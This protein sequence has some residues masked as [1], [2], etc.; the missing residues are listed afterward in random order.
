MKPEIIV[1]K[2][3]GF[4][5][6]VDRAV[7]MCD[8][9]LDEGYKVATLGPIIH[10]ETVVRRLESKGCIIIK[11]PSEAPEGTTVVIRSHGVPASVYE[12]C[13]KAG[14]N[15][16]DAT[17]PFVAKIHKIAQKTGEEGRCLV[18]AGDK[19]H[20]E[21]QGIVGHCSGDVFVV[22]DLDE[23][24]AAAEKIG[25]REAVM[26]SQTTFSKEKF[27]VL[28]EF[29]KK[30]YTTFSVFDTI[31]N[32]TNMRQKE[33]LELSRECDFCIVIG[34]MN[35]SNTGKLKE[36]C[37]RNA[38]TVWIQSADEL[39]P[40]GLGGYEKIGITAGA[41]TPFPV[42]EEVLIRMSEE[43]K[44]FNFETELEE[45]LKPVHR[46]QRVDGMVIAIGPTEVTVDIG[47]K[48]TGFV[49]LDELTDDS[50]AKPEDVVKVG[51]TYTFLVTKVQDLEGVVTLSRKKVENE[52][53][54]KVLTDAFESGEPVDA[55]IT[56]VVSKGLVA[57]V[58]GARVFIPGSQATLR[59]GEQYEQLLHTHQMIKIIEA[60]K[61]RRRAIGSIRAVLEAENAKK[62]EEFFANVEVGKVYTGV[63]KSMTSYGAFVDLGGVD[64]MI[65]VSEMSWKR[66]H[67]PAEIFKIGDEVQVYVKEFDAEKGRISLGYRREEDNPWNKIH[68]YAIG[69]EFNAPVVSITKFG[70]FVRIL[71]DLDGLVHLSEMS[72]AHVDDPAKIV[73]VGEE[74]KVRLIGIDE[75]HKRISLSMLAE[76]EK[77]AARAA[78]REAKAAEKAAE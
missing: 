53:G 58:K 44:E 63:I 65:H 51:D 70:A 38:P 75:E 28:A 11:E 47:R 59:R 52:A 13:E 8:K 10:N 77:E 33:A 20:P 72:T 41:S 73:K 49:P 31:C 15:V 35:S 40:S 30:C 24:K 19:D 9:L 4:C 64:G 67:N 3:A 32:A 34:G 66:I 50:S 14:L 78:A 25:G 29:A 22:K 69:S 1:A 74:V 42:I 76:G 7:K 23:L 16:V 6:G 43:V 46:G 5:F 45:S 37:E 71:P 60:D 55:Y 2:T 54:L 61:E 36:I 27:S 17:C 68:D 48:Q 39:N 12:D 26:V 18:I 57:N 21:V 56:E 62:K